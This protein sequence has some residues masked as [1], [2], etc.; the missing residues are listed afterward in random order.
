MGLG[1]H[2]AKPTATREP[3]SGEPRVPFATR[4]CNLGCNYY[5]SNVPIGGAC[6]PLMTQWRANPFGTVTSEP[7]P[8]FAQGAPRL[9]DPRWPRWRR[10]DYALVPVETLSLSPS[11]FERVVLKTHA[12][13][14]DRWSSASYPPK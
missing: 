5:N 7:M 8:S 14:K 11:A 4:G 2:F 13:S 6:N 9:E 12:V 3:L 1:A 10:A